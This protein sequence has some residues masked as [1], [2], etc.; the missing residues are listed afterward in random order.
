M[1]GI[2][3]ICGYQ[4]SGKTTLLSSIIT[5]LKER[6]VKAAVLKHHGHGGS[7][8][9]RE[10][11]KDSEQYIQ[12]GAVASLAEGQ[13][14]IQLLANI[15]EFDLDQQIR[16]ISFFKPDIIL[17]EG[18][19]YENFPKIVLLKNR[20][21]LTLLN[22]LTNIKA[23]VYWEEAEGEE[24]S[25]KNNIKHLSLF[26]PSLPIQLCEMIMKENLDL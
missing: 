3:Q 24:K 12:A 5:A 10:N 19:K 25:E 16:F 1:T 2:F 4:N 8:T 21:D 14:H 26:D 7:L 22:D 23:A 15:A 9:V 20:E 13:G 6:N 17:I 11:Q 18:Y